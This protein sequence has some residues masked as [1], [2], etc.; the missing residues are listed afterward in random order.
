MSNFTIASIVVT[1]LFVTVVLIVD[2]VEVARANRIASNPHIQE[3]LSKSE[4]ERSFQAYLQDIGLDGE[5]CPIEELV[6]AHKQH[7]MIVKILKTV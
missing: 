5:N 3:W 7:E 1:C 2:H 6:A 4:E